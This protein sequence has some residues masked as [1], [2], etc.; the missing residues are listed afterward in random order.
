MLLIFLLLQPKPDDNASRSKREAERL[1]GFIKKKAKVEWSCAVCKFSASSERQLNE[2]LQ[3]RKHKNEESKMQRAQ[4][5]SKN[6][7]TGLSSKKATKCTS[8]A[9]YLAF[10]ETQVGGLKKDHL[11]SLQISLNSHSWKKNK[12]KFD[13]NIRMGEK[14]MKKRHR[15]HQRS[16]KRANR[17]HVAEQNRGAGQRMVPAMIK[18][19]QQW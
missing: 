16:K 2:H 1:D 8:A 17:L 4:K 18:E 19:P 15:A 9:E 3:G 10:G 7:R 11:P 14:H 13:P 5:G 12:S 6:Y